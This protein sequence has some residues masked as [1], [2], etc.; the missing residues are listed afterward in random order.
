MTWELFTYI[1]WSKP[2]NS[3]TCSVFYLL[4]YLK[5]GRS[6]F[7]RLCSA[8]EPLQ[9]DYSAM[10]HLP[11]HFSAQEHFPSQFSALEIG[12]LILIFVF[13]LLIPNYKI[14]HPWLPTIDVTY[15]VYKLFF[16]KQHFPQLFTSFLFTELFNILLKD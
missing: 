4:L 2:V 1:P 13:I 6:L 8:L 9:S 10:E 14:S 15:W 5:I 12:K 11:K 16:C 7:E 3:F